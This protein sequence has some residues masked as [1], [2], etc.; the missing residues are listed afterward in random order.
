MKKAAFYQGTIVLV[1]DEFDSFTSFVEDVKKH[2]MQ[3]LVTLHEKDC[4]APYFLQEHCEIKTLMIS[5]PDELIEIEADVLTEKEYDD[6]LHEKMKE[7]HIDSSLSK[8]K[9]TMTL[10]GTFEREYSVQCYWEA[11]QEFWKLFKKEEELMRQSMSDSCEQNDHLRML[12]LTCCGIPYNQCRVYVRKFKKKHVMMITCLADSLYQILVDAVIHHSPSELNQN[13]EFYGFLPRQVYQYVPSQEDY[14][15]SYHPCHLNV[16]KT[17]FDHLR[18]DIE[19]EIEPSSNFAFACEENYLYMCSILGENLFHAVVHSFSWNATKERQ[20]QSVVDFYLMLMK[21]FQPLLLMKL[22]GHMHQ[23]GLRLKKQETF[24]ERSFDQHII[25]RCVE[26]TDW[27]VLEKPSVDL[28]ALQMELNVVLSTL[29]FE[30]HEDED[31]EIQ[32]REILLKLM[33]LLVENSYVEIID[34]CISNDRIDVDLMTFDAAGLFNL[35][36]KNAP[37]FEKYSCRY[38]EYTVE[39]CNRYQVSYTMKKKKMEFNQLH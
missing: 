14:D 25:T 18:Y 10:D 33:K 38:D 32:R 35:L 24:R 31:K 37:L 15:A 16:K 34:Y 9:K 39:S 17:E 22:A 2:P 6:R 8:I 1:P 19:F 5:H 36:R 29:V 28:D 11:I 13:W 27:F 4:L 7:L 20:G 12:L 21:S 26:C 3:V 23:I 30:L